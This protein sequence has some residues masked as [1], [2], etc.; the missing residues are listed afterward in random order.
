MNQTQ[1]PYDEKQPIREQHKQAW[2]VAVV[3]VFHESANKETG[4]DLSVAHDSNLFALSQKIA[5]DSS[6]SAN[7]VSISVQK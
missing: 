2:P 7:I 5:I 3:T 6:G 4:D 1:Q